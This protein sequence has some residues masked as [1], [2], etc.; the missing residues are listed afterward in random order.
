MVL[1]LCTSQVGNPALEYKNKLPV[2][3]EILLFHFKPAAIFFP[4]QNMQM[5]TQIVYMA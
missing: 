2:I 3:Q 5:K 4:I 1:P